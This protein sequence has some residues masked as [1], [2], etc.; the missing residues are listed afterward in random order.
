[1]YAYT[2]LLDIEQIKSVKLS[3]DIMKKKSNDG[4]STGCIVYSEQTRIDTR[5]TVSFY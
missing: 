2:H 1:M 4:L 3:A 5:G